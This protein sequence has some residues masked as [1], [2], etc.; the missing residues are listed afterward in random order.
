MLEFMLLLIFSFIQ[1][2]TMKISLI[3]LAGLSLLIASGDAFSTV[4]PPKAETKSTTAGAPA[5][6]EETV[7]APTSEARWEI[8]GTTAS[9]PA[10]NLAEYDGPVPT[11]VKTAGN[12]LTDALE[13]PEGEVPNFDVLAKTIEFATQSDQ[14]ERKKLFATDFVFR[15]SVVGPIIREDILDAQNDFNIKEA[16]PNLDTRPFGFTVDPDD[17]FRCYYFERWEGTNTGDLKLGPVK[18]KATGND[19]KVPTHIMSLHYNRE[20]L[21]RYACLSSPL[22]R[23][24]GNTGGAGAVFGLLAGG[25]GLGF[26]NPVVG[27]TA[28][29]LFTRLGH[30]VGF[31]K[32]RAWSKEID[33]PRWWASKARGADPNDM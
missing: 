25:G 6:A 31:S 14:A 12:F 32:G 21:V 23:F 5:A 9:Q 4:S 20:G 24:E 26:L 33:I 3:P 27:D 11:K 22:D 2:G 16:Y 8:T 13:Y 10:A 17:P 29:R 19:V 28:T 15:G 30:A 7:A 18:L 1:N